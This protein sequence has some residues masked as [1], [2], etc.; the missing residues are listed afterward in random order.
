GFVYIPGKGF[1]WPK[2]RDVTYGQ[3][4][5]LRIFAEDTSDRFARG[6]P[7]PWSRP[8]FFR[9]VAATQTRRTCC[10]PHPRAC[11]SPDPLEALGVL[12]PA[13]H[14]DVGVARDRLRGF[15]IEGAEHARRRSYDQ[16][17]VRKFLAL[18]HH[19]AGAAEAI[20]SDPRAVEHHRAHTDQAVRRDGAAVQ[21]HVMADDAILADIEGKAGI[22]VQHRVVL[23]LRALAELDPFV[24]AA[25]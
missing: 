1:L 20:L 24:V 6:R 13:P 7:R 11:P 19:G 22:G 21:D 10:A 23:D 8:R 14:I 4:K 3:C 25:Q 5:S 15:F 9:G 18:G 2:P 12:L 16:R 17:I